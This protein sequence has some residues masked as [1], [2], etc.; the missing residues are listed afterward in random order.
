M[1]GRARILVF[2]N[3]FLIGGQERQTILNVRTMDRDRFEPIVA[4]LHLEGEHLEDLAAAGIRPLLVDIGRK[5]LRPRVAVAVARLARLLRAERIALVHA[6]DIYTNAL[7]L[8][9][10]RAAG[11]PA[12]VTRV[13]L[14]H[15]VVG[16]RRPLTRLATRAADRVLVNA[17]CIRDLVV[18]EG[19]EPDRVVVV[20][21]GLDL[22][23]QDRAARAEP[24]AGAPVDGEWIVNVA[25]MH[26]PVKGQTDLLIAFR[27]VLRSHPAARLLLVGDGVRRPLLE[28]L[29]GELGI[30]TR[31][32]FLG[33]RRDGAALLARAA[34]AVSAS[35][36]EGISN[37]ILEAMAARLPVV[38]TAV[39]GTPEL[40]RDGVTGMLAP[41]GSPGAL[42]RRMEDVLADPARA[43]RMGERGRRVVQREF[44]VRQMRLGYD[45][46]YDELAA[47]KVPRRWAG[48][49]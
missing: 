22:A 5:M 25:N 2:Q 11:I 4:C 20:R 36:A 48:M 27:E 40:V 28:K 47:F 34:L 39:G 16:Y 1:N 8:L 23:A 10:A 14:G 13:D 32:H 37:A 46:L 12:V 17:L 15:H 33:F 21:N 38:A 19:V 49:G 6:Q 30:A 9:A 26:H 42:A 44:D 24:A 7:G 43:R 41:P 29:A 45:A 3:R 18:R 31:V 35:H